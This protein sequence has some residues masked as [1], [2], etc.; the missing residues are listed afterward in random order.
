MQVWKYPIPTRDTFDLSLPVGARI[1]SVHTQDNQPC[2]W[3]HVSPDA[4]KELREF[5]TC[6]TGHDMPDDEA[7]E[8]IGTFLIDNGLLVFHLFEITGYEVDYYQKKE[9][10]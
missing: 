4:P 1:L 2:L 6:G 3:A 7:H 8:F 9:D 5:R 10:I